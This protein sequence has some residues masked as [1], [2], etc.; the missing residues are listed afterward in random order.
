MTASSPRPL[1]RRIPALA[2]TVAVA[3]AALVVLPTQ[4]A[5]AAISDCRFGARQ[6]FDVQWSLNGTTLSTS[7]IT[8]PY[9]N[10]GPF[11]PTPGPLQ[12]SDAI[13]APTDYFEFFPSTTDPGTLGLA[14]HAQDGTLRGVIQETGEFY[15]LGTDVL[16]YLGSGF[17]GTVITTGEAYPHGSSVDFTVSTVNP[18]PAEVDAYD[19]CS[20]DPIAVVRLGP[21]LPA[22]GIVGTGYT[23]FSIPLIGAADPGFAVLSG[24]LPPGLVLDTA[25]GVI[26]G[27]PTQ[28][29]TFAFTIRAEDVNGV[30]EGD[31]SITVTAPAVVPG[32]TDP[33]PTVTGP[34]LAEGGA[35]EGVLWLGAGGVLAAAAG[36]WLAMRRRARS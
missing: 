31:Y 21:E 19:S 12:L 3:A 16:F 14:L 18:T 1:S 7:D 8:F 27:T 2:A 22:A 24:A 29:G 32:P 15:A 35:R 26:S 33:E 17:W 25:T 9:S 10:F 6:V 28:P 23:S 36:A 5:S 4:S 13:I 34:Q 30:V 11:A 20:A